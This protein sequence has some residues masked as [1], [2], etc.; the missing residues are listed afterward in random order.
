MSNKEKNNI[1]ED[2]EIKDFA[3]EDDLLDKIVE[4]SDNLE[5]GQS[6][7]VIAKS[8]LIEYLLVELVKEDFGVGIIDFNS[9]GDDY[10]NEYILQMYEDKKVS[11]F[12]LR[13]ICDD[14]DRF[15]DI[16]DTY[17]FL[18]EKDIKQDLV[19]NALNNS[20]SP[21]LFGFIDEYE[22]DEECDKCEITVN[23]EVSDVTIK[24]T[25]G[26]NVQYFHL[27]FEN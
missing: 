13:Y 7:A 2:L 17:V 5:D 8:D 6:I 19:N 27:N 25:F 16:S 4:I 9:F 15:Y 22:E 24:G 1:Y 23:I 12:P 11:I 10:Y 14:E 21:T 26:D 20:D 3:D 18:Y